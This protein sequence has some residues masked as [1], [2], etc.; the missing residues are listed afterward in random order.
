MTATSDDA[1]R[2]RTELFGEHA[3]TLARTDPEMADYFD[4]FTYDETLSD[5]AVLD[6]SL[7]VRTRLLVQLG[8]TLA[9]G[10]LSQFRVLAAAGIEL[11]LPGRS[12]STPETRVEFGKSVQAQIVGGR[13]AVEKRI[14]AA[15]P[16]CWPC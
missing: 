6:E 3:S 9:A 12:S 10:G 15:R 13:D 14:A 2:N 8:A 5:A 16:A 7:D 4:N 11:P 1:R